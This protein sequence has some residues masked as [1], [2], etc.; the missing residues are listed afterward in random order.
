MAKTKYSMRQ[1]AGVEAV[2]QFAATH[3]LSPKAIQ[4]LH[5]MIKKIIDD[6]SFLIKAPAKKKTKR[7]NRL[8]LGDTVEAPFL[9]E[10]GHVVVN[11]MFHGEI[12]KVH[13][14]D[15]SFAVR[16]LDGDI[17]PVV[18]YALITP[19]ALRDFLQAFKKYVKR[20]E[21]VEGTLSVMKWTEDRKAVGLIWTQEGDV[22]KPEGIQSI[23]PH[24]TYK[25]GDMVTSPFVDIHGRT[26][27]DGNYYGEIVSFRGCDKVDV[28]FLD[29]DVSQGALIDELIPISLPKFLI[30]FSE[31]KAMLLSTV[32]EDAV[33]SWLEERKESQLMWTEDHPPPLMTFS[34]GDAVLAPWPEEVADDEKEGT[35][36]MILYHA[37]VTTVYLSAMTVDVEYLDGRK[38]YGI[39]V[40]QISPCS[41]E[42]Y[43][44]A[45]LNHYRSLQRLPAGTKTAD[46]WNRDRK[47]RSLLSAGC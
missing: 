4:D 35:K 38:G 2:D 14:D 26:V 11:G 46:A 37:Q 5:D 30:E 12:I 28:R 13:E 9:D 25:I 23:R 34:L 18:P 27:V 1:M 44:S 41:A 19:L 21:K 31:Y 43:K 29:G 3:R 6:S 36:T 45:V 22:A 8:S 47:G 24:P 15:A 33:E 39:Q 10:E 32:G 17:S 20:L 42:D 7:S 40:D 16:F